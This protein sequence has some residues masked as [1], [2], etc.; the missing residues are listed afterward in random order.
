MT[1]ACDGAD[2]LP[3]I[4]IWNWITALNTRNPVQKQ[5][6][7]MDS[8]DNIIYQSITGT[9]LYMLNNPSFLKRTVK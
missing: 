9:L 5:Q 1:I 6:N 4:E 3:E 8:T 7:L 2:K